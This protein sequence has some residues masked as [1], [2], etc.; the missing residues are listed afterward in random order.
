MMM[1]KCVCSSSSPCWLVLSTSIK[2]EERKICLPL[3]FARVDD[4]CFLG[5]RGV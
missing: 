3:V 2:N 4:G 5:T 1:Y